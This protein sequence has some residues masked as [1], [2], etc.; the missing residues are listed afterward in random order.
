MNLTETLPTHDLKQRLANSINKIVDR[1]SAHWLVAINL[2]FFM[3]VGLPFAAPILLANDHSQIANAIYSMYR[4]VCHQMPSH[5]Y[6]IFGEQMAICERCTAIYLSMAVGGL[7]Y[8]MLRQRVKA[9]PFKWY[10][11]FLVPIAVDGGTA[12]FSVWLEYFPSVIYG[13]WAVGLTILAICLAILYKQ[14]LLTWQG[15]LFFLAGPLS[16]IYL[17]IVGFHTS[18]WWLRAITASIFALGTIWLAYPS[19]EEG[20]GETRN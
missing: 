6:F 4:F 20:F 9:L 15:L 17:Q 13:L 2:F 7:I 3:Y 14:R 10:I 1:L 5:S 19:F 8:A 16:L 12:M 18:N 11:L